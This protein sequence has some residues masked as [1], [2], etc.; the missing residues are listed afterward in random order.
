MNIPGWQFLITFKIV[1]ETSTKTVCTCYAIS[2][3]TGLDAKDN[4]MFYIKSIYIT[5]NN[6][7]KKLLAS[8]QNMHTKMVRWK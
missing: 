1:A 8:R 3:G 2:I 4:I 5:W 6:D 7:F